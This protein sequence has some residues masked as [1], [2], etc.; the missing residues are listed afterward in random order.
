MTLENITNHENHRE[1]ITR[2][3][4]DQVMDCWHFD[5]DK[6]YRDVFE[7]LDQ[8]F[9]GTINIIK[10]ELTSQVQ[11]EAYRRQSTDDFKTL[12]ANEWAEN[13]HDTSRLPSDISVAIVKLL[14]D[15]E[16]YSFS[17][18]NFV[19]KEALTEQQSK[20]AIQI[21]LNHLVKIFQ[22]PH[23]FGKLGIFHFTN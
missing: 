23:L 17:M 2:E 20:I 19:S 5:I 4:S 6:V 14:T 8:H 18:R 12:F 11:L 16:F 15:D 22:V 13:L 1:K 3:Q 7:K 10:S 9:Y 21:I